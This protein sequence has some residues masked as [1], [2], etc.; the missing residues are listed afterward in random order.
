MLTIRNGETTTTFTLR[1]MRAE[2]LDEV[3]DRIMSIEIDASAI[4]AQH[5]IGYRAGAGAMRQAARALIT[6][7]I[8]E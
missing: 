7:M 4:A 1:R 5:K 8:D 3:R 2:I 6:D